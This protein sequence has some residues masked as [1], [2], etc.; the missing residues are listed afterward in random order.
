MRLNVCRRPRLRKASV[1]SDLNVHVGAVL[2]LQDP[3][4]MGS[5]LPSS[6]VYLLEGAAQT[7]SFFSPGDKTQVESRIPFSA[8]L[9]S[10]RLLTPVY[11]RRKRRCGSG[12]RASSGLW[13]GGPHAGH[14]A[15][16]ESSPPLPADALEDGAPG[17]TRPGVRPRFRDS[18]C[19]RDTALGH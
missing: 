9:A 19:R 11:T 7:R 14:T 15:A 18:L 10:L 13:R 2:A 17:P 12:P 1:G 4:A 3:P 8:H 6:K 16:P 5:A